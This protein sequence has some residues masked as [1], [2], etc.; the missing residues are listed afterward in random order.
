M[1]RI[2]RPEAAETIGRHSEAVETS[3]RD[4]ARLTGRMRRVQRG[5]ACRGCAASAFSRRPIG[6]DLEPVK[7]SYP[8]TRGRRRFNNMFEEEEFLEH[9]KWCL[10]A[11]KLWDEYIEGKTSRGLASVE[12]ERTTC[13]LEQQ[14]ER[15]AV[16]SKLEV[17]SLQAAGL[18]R[19][20]EEES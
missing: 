14:G 20:R 9:F 5:L 3:E 7:P 18:E 12:D 6:V 13:L 1:A 19:Q 10:L 2:L 16:C 8:L 17:R 11:Q 4:A 15:E